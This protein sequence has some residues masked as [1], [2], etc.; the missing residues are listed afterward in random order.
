MLLSKGYGEQYHLYYIQHISCEIFVDSCTWPWALP[1]EYWN[2][3]VPPL[4]MPSDNEK[5]QPIHAQLEITTNKARNIGTSLLGRFLQVT[6]ME[7]LLEQIFYRV[8]F[9]ESQAYSPNPWSLM[10]SFSPIP[11]R[12]PLWLPHHRQCPWSSQRSAKLE[13][14]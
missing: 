7:S 5:L 10:S 11:S 6:N 12:N 4:S 2:S 14:E 13:A 1:F 8:Y 3:H 9:A